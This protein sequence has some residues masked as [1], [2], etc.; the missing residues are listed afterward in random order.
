[1]DWGEYEGKTLAE[2]QAEHGDTFV[3]NERQGLDFQPPGGESP[4]QV[5]HRLRPWLQRL[6]AGK[7]NVGAITHR[8]VIRAILA[9]A[10]N[11][12]ILGKPPVKTDRKSVVSGKSVSVRVELVGSRIIKKK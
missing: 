4:R 8:G 2:L 11:W 10:Y 9:E 1:M 12:P 7:D 5:Q 3:A 6:A